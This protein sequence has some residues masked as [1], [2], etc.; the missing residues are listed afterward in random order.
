MLEEFPNAT[1]LR[2]TT[3]V[4]MNDY[5]T[6]DFR[7]TVETWHKRYYVFNDCTQ[8]RQ[9]ICYNDV[10]AAVL[11]ALKLEESV[12]QIY[13]LGGP[14]VYSRLQMYE[15]MMNAINVDVDLL[16]IDNDF[17]Q[18][19]AQRI[20]NW[21]FFSLDNIIKDDIDLVV[22]PSAKKIEDLYISPVSFSKVCEDVLAPFHTLAPPTHDELRA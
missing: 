18:W 15:M 20:I 2:P 19:V 12:G 17:A 16:R 14:H 8:L 4:G 6:Y 9:P 22:D 7:K 5:L 10:A 3:M 1:I 21:R 11:N 13:E